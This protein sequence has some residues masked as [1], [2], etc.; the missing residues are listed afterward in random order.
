MGIAP[1]TLTHPV[2]QVAHEPHHRSHADIVLSPTPPP[3][4]PVQPPWQP[5]RVRAR[6]DMSPQ[7]VPAAPAPPPART[8]ISPV[9]PTIDARARPEP[10]PAPKES[11]LLAQIRDEEK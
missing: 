3:K 7:P 5:A 1:L 2:D 8:V 10:K 4:A 9:V 6:V 11:D